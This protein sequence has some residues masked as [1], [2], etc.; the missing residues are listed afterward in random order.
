MKTKIVYVLASLDADVYMEQAFV[1]AW[2]ARHYNPDC[3]IEMVC[4]QDTFA[5]MKSGIRGQYKSLFDTF[6]VQDFRPEQS[7]RERSRWMKTSLRKLIEGDY[8]FLDSDTVVCSNLSHIDDYNFSIGM[9][10]DQNCEMKDFLYR[11]GVTNRTKRLFN[12]DISAETKYFNSGVAYVKDN[13]QTHI[14]YK[15]WHQMWMSKRYENDGIK[16]QAS[17]AATNLLLGH[18]ITEMS[19]DMNCQ[20]MASIQYLHTAHIMHFFNT[21]FTAKGPSLHPFYGKNLFLEVKEQGITKDIVH[22]ILQCKSLFISP[23]VPVPFEGAKIWELYS[24]RNIFNTNAWI[25]LQYIHQSHPLVFKFIE[26]FITT[27]IRFRRRCKRYI[28][29]L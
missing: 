21:F 23:S 20:V 6:H 27:L 7:M 9:A 17:L 28:S 25:T 16:D 12:V 10:L 13:A 26:Y 15:K 14:F 22:K 1:S 3:H 19:G 11:T 5:T 24:K 4:D 2:S 18:V 29:K 8:L